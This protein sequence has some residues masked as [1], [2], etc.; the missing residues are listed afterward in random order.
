[1]QPRLYKKQI[2]SI[3]DSGDVSLSAKEEMPDSN[4]LFLSQTSIFSLWLVE[5]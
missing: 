3:W 4:S 2:I 1:M 5:L